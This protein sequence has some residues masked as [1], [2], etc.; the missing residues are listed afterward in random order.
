MN[1]EELQRNLQQLRAAMQQAARNLELETAAALRDEI[2]EMERALKEKMGDFAVGLAA[3]GSGTYQAPRSGRPARGG[4]PKP[5]EPGYR[6]PR[7]R[8]GR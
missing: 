4:P 1:L 8:K 7:A 6:T 3:E 5:G 2:F